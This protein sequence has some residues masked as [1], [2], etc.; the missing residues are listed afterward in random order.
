MEKSKSCILE[1]MENSKYC[2]GEIQ[3][4]YWRNPNHVLEKSKSCFGEIQIMYWG[5]PNHV[6]EKSK[7]C[8]GSEGVE[9]WAPL[10]FD[11]WL[12]PTPKALF[13]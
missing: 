12:S 6:L 13:L 3:I 9:I 8:M 1:N 4:M 10:L 7:T 5:N 11:I 2:I